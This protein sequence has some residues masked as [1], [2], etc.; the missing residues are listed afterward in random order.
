MCHYS[1][2]RRTPSLI[3][4]CTKTGRHKSSALHSLL[5]LS[6]LVF[7]YY[8]IYVQSNLQDL[9]PKTLNSSEAQQTA[10]SQHLCHTQKVVIH[11]S[12]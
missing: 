12:Q 10:R 6:R 7:F 2:R 11:Y 1:F 4:T 5:L 3:H 9:K 8:F